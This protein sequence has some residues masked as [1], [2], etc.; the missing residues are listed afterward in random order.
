MKTCKWRVVLRGLTLP[1]VLCFLVASVWAQDHA[2]QNGPPEKERAFKGLP[3]LLASNVSPKTTDSSEKSE[4]AKKST[5]S[6]KDPVEKDPTAKKDPASG[7]GSAAPAP[8]GAEDPPLG[9]AGPKTVKP[10]KP[11]VTDEQESGDFV[12]VDDRWRIGFPEWDRHGDFTKAD[13]PYV[14]GRLINPYRQNVLKGDYPVFGNDKFFTLKLIS[15][16]N[17]NVRRA[18]TL[19]DTST[20]LPDGDE[21]FGRTGQFFYSQYFVIETD[22]FKGD[23]SFKPA[24]WR[25]HALVDFNINYAHVRENGILRIDDRRGNTRRDGIIVLQE[26]FAEYRVG[27]TPRFLP[28]LR[29]KGSQGGYS[30]FFDTT[31]IRAGIQCFNSDFRGFIFND[32]NLGARL[33]GNFKANRYQFNLAYFEMLEKDTNSGLNTFDTRNQEVYI[34]N[35]YRQDTFKKGYTIEFS[36]HHNRDNK[37]FH[38]DKNGFPVRPA[39]FGFAVPHEIRSHYIGFTTEGH[40]GERLPKFL[41]L[42][43]IG[44]G[45]NVSSSFYQVLGTDSFNGLAG[46]KVDINAQLAAVELSVDRDWA[47]FRTSFQYA[48][49]DDKPTDGTARGFDYILDDNNFTGGKNSFFNSQFIP[50]LSTTTGLSTP[51]S[52]IPNLRSSK[53]EGQA[54]HVNPGIMIYNVGFDADITQKLKL[55]TNLNFIRFH[56]TQTLELGEFQPQIEKFLGIDYSSGFKYRPKLNDNIVILFG[57][58]IFRPGAAFTSIFESNCNPAGPANCG[59]QTGN[60]TLFNLFTSVKFQY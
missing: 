28:F 38:N 50:F 31:T 23:A 17:L 16:S 40:F 47:R 46:R 12:P 6:E 36:Y 19:S 1:L 43:K 39:V 59:S 44:G 22:F 29:G 15:I 27:D 55:I 3:N 57:A 48:S 32:C 41:F 51:N 45:L 25:F 49:G 18:P 2:Q 60:K 24:D 52:N 58:S 21:F 37:S 9:F 8:A 53:I 26:G 4:Q 10:S 5:S 42:N 33:F 11:M 56:H 13:Y 34:A 54:N 14:K 30:P 7:G 20:R 35:L